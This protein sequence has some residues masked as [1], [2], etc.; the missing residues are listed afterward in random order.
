MWRNA[1]ATFTNQDQ[2]S[3]NQ[4]MNNQSVLQQQQQS[5]H[6]Q[7][8]EELYHVDDVLAMID[9]EG[10]HTPVKRPNF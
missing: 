5:S 1:A 4:L 2:E 7:N 10:H 3:Q 8:H 6:V 9:N